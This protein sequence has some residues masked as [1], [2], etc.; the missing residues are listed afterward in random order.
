MFLTVSDVAA[1]YRV[2]E[3]TVWRWT[4][5]AADPFPAPLYFH[6]HPTPGKGL[7]RKGSL[8]R[9]RSRDLLFYEMEQQLRLE[10]EHPQFYAAKRGAMLAQ[11]RRMYPELRLPPEGEELAAKQAYDAGQQ[12]MLHG[13]LMA[14]RRAE[15]KAAA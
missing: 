2:S 8:A 12:R 15:K 6:E 5:D 11:L 13:A 7:E 3:H 4:N 9:W 1:R 10:D 14:A